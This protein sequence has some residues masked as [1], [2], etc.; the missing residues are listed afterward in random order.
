MKIKIYKASIVSLI[1]VFSFN[2]FASSADA[3]GCNFTRDLSLGMRGEDVLCLQQYL[4]S[5]PNGTVFTGF[6]PMDANFGPLTTQA[7]MQWQTNNGVFP[8]S[9]FFGAPSRAR[10]L[11]LSIGGANTFGGNS[12][13]NTTVIN[14]QEERARQR[15]V[16]ALI[17]IE[18][19]QDEIDDSNRN[20][21]SAENSLEDAKDDMLDA[22]RAFF[23]DRD[24]FGAFDSADDA[25]QNAEDAF[26][27][28]DGNRNRNNNDRDSAEEVIDDARDAINDAQDE[29]ND[30]DDDGDDVDEA[31]D[32]L[33]DAEDRLDEAEEEFD[34]RN[35]DEAQDLAEEAKDLADDAVDAIR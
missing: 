26:D 22:M 11:E 31:E 10:Y 23:I 12:F 7:V 29:I 24:F 3:V 6:I 33:R 9:G 18:D 17:M 2:I 32:I 35:F 5:S 27:E 34:D 19:A 13:F 15:I 4:N 1:A 8:A 16:D 28:A 20:T 25:F 30:A 14:S 21:S